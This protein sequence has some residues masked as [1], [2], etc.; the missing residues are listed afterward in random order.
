VRERI[1]EIAWCMSISDK[2]VASPEQ[3]NLL[4]DYYFTGRISDPASNRHFWKRFTADK[5]TLDGHNRK[6]ALDELAEVGLHR[7]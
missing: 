5:T 4:I 2:Q 7:T 1:W 3:W 6:A